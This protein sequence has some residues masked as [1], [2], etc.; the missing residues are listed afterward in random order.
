MVGTVFF[1]SSADPKSGF[2]NPTGSLRK[3]KKRQKILCDTK[4]SFLAPSEP[5]WTRDGANRVYSSRSLDCAHSRK[6]I[7]IAGHANLTIKCW[8]HEMAFWGDRDPNVETKKYSDGYS[9]HIPQVVRHKL[10]GNRQELPRGVGKMYWWL[11][12]LEKALE[13]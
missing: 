11:A 10:I 8:F 1:K 2:R 4:L 13:N 7:L 9:G 6:V 3:R 5:I 12:Q